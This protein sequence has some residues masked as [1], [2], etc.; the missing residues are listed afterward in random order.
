MEQLGPRSFD[1]YF[2]PYILYLQGMVTPARFQHCLRTADMIRRAVTARAAV[3]E[4]KAILAGLLH[5]VAKDLPF[6]ELVRQLER[7]D[8]R[9][10]TDLPR[11]CQ[12]HEVYL[13]G[14][15]G[16]VIVRRAIDLDD[17]DILHAIS[18]HTGS[19]PN[20]EPLTRLVHIADCAE[21]GRNLAEREDL[22]RAFLD[23]RIDDAELI[24][25]RFIVRFFPTMNTPVHPYYHLKI[26]AL[27]RDYGD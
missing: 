2:E 5:D 10:L 1:P 15:V 22:E 4:R 7:Y 14:P 13:H 17:P 6:E 11:A 9:S 8:A 25:A 21:R 16:A 23:G 19:Y 24:I 26:R 27:S 12:G 3:D 18:R 20:L